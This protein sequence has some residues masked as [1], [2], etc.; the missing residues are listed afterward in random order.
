M[1]A[2]PPVIGGTPTSLKEKQKLMAKNVLDTNQGVVETPK[3]VI[4]EKQIESE[5]KAEEPEVK[6]ITVEE[7]K[8]E[9][10]EAAKRGRK[11][12]QK[13][14]MTLHA[15]IDTDIME[16]LDQ[17]AEETRHNKSMIVNDILAAYMKN[18]RQD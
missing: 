4:M 5:T 13:G 8:E 6:Q 15:T 3:A 12:A 7:K 2:K 18:H 1:S 17:L 9:P 16:F 14:K 10:K 11:P